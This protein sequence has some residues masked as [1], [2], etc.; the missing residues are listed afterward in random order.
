M[1]CIRFAHRFTEVL[2]EDFIISMARTREAWVIPI[3]RDQSGFTQWPETARLAT[4]ND[5]QASVW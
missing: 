3:R 1:I 4:R 5:E 2:K